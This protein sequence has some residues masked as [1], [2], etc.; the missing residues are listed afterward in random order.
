VTRLEGPVEHAEAELV[1]QIPM[2]DGGREL[3]ACSRG[4]AHL[5]GDLL[6]IPILARPCRGFGYF[7]RH[8]GRRR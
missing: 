2:E 5:E 6:I 4:L 1:L 3:V 7:G 8:P